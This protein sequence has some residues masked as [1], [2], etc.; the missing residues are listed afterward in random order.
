MCADT[1]QGMR[2]Y[3][4]IIIVLVVEHRDLRF[5]IKKHWLFPDQVGRDCR[6]V[7]IPPGWWVRAHTPPVTAERDWPWQ[8]LLVC[9][10]DCHQKQRKQTQSGAS[11]NTHSS[12]VIFIFPSSLYS[13]LVYFTYSTLFS[14]PLM[15]L[16][17]AT[18]FF[19][20]LCANVEFFLL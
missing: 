7:W 2:H 20:C 9:R 10:C 17:Y 6:C 11:S 5:V 14:P 1:R 12:H 3:I 18:Y 13:Q 16:N 8:R 19:K 4:N 15:S